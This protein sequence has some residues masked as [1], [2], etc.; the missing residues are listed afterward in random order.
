MNDLIITLSVVFGLLGLGV[1][2][3]S[4]SQKTQGTKQP[5]IKKYSYLYAIRND[6]YDLNCYK[7]GKSTASPRKTISRYQTGHHKPFYFML[8][9]K[10]DPRKLSKA[11]NVLKITF[12]SRRMFPNST[13]REMFLFSS[14][15]E[16]KEECSKALLSNGIKYY[17]LIENHEYDNRGYDLK[18]GNE[19]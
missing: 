17:D 13:Q 14:Y 9:W 16:L 3:H 19:H 6:T 5:N 4:L 15:P 11:E 7:L 12:A 10:V 1:G 2:A 8:L 18:P